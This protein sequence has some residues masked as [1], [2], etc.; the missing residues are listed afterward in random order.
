MLQKKRKKRSGTAK[1]LF[2]ILP[3]KIIL[4]CINAWEICEQSKKLE[5]RT[6]EF[7]NHSKPLRALIDGENKGTLKV[8]ARIKIGKTELIEAGQ[9]K[10]EQQHPVSGNFISRAH[11]SL[12]LGA[13]EAHK[14]ITPRKPLQTCCL[15]FNINKPLQIQSNYQAG[16]LTLP[17][18][19][20]AR[21]KTIL[22]VQLM[23]SVEGLLAVEQLSFMISEERTSKNSLTN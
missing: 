7:S 17:F 10:N 19:K 13:T 18:I 9:T 2:H 1:P 22:M 6:A 5:N 23:V 16:P 8:V 14:P 12:L 3:S 20:L 21:K 4:F 11:N 15:I